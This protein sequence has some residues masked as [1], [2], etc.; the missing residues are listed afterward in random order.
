[1]PSTY[2]V[3]EAI[4]T[5]MQL[6]SLL[7]LFVGRLRAVRCLHPDTRKNPLAR[8]GVQESLRLQNKKA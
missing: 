8:A 4:L 6:V 5:L 1:M 2:R 3:A 7:G